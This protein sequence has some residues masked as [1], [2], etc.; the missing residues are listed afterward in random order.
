MN[1]KDCQKHG[2]KHNPARDGLE[3]VMQALPENQGGA[4][5]HKCPYCAYERGYATGLADG[6]KRAANVLW[7]LAQEQD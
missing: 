1:A 4:G 2:G 3:V 6:I 7:A 5:R